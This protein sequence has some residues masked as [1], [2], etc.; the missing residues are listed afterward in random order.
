MTLTPWLLFA[1]LLLLLP[2]YLVIEYTTKSPWRRL[3]IKSACSLL[4]LLV[5]AAAMLGAPQGRQ[6]YFGW[7]TAA[8]LLCAAGDV[9]LDWPMEK[10]FLLGLGS[11]LLAQ[12]TFAVAFSLRWGLSPWDAAIYAL[13]AG[14]AVTTLRRAPGMEYGQAGAPVSIYALALSAMAAKAVSGVYLNGGTGAWLAAA[15]GLMFFASDVVLAFTLFNKK[16]PASLRGVNLLLYYVGQGL[17]A[18]SLAFYT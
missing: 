5:A 11:F 9:L 1:V 18:V 2:V 12:C 7:F 16:K 14:A 3:A 8:F 17:L 13:L 4:F 6:V 10:S 15:G